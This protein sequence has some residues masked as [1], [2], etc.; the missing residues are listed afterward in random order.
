MVQMNV[1]VAIILCN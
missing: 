1:G